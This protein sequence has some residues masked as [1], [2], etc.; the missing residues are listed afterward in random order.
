[1][2]LPFIRTMASSEDVLIRVADERL[3]ELK[4]GGARSSR[5]APPRPP[6]PQAQTQ[7][8][9]KVKASFSPANP[10]G[11]TVGVP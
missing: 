9:K 2:D 1:M 3:Y 6:R 10:P 4:K 8:L 11:E 7:F 5:P